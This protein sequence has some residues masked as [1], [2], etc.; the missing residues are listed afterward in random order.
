VSVSR[1]GYSPRGS[2]WSHPA[3][4]TLVRRDMEM[5]REV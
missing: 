4:R 1:H 2:R 3:S 5:R